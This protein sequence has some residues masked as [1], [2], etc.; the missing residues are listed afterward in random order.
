MRWL[1]LNL[2]LLE[3]RILEI[4][5][6]YANLLKSIIPTIKSK[7]N[8][9]AIDEIILFWYKNM[10]S[11]RLYLKYVFSQKDSYVFTAATFLDYD[12]KEHYPFL[13]LGEKHILDDPLCK[14]A[15]L[16][17]TFPQDSKSSLFKILNEQI[18]LTAE[19]N[20]KIIDNCQN[21]IIV[22]PLRILS[23]LDSKNKSAIIDIGEKTFLSL[24]NDID[25][26]DEY[27]EKLNT[28][29]SIKKQFIDGIEETL[30][31]SETDD[32]TKPFETRFAEAKNNSPI[33]FDKEKS[34]AYCFF[35]SFTDLYS[36]P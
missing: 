28:I 3:N 10:D 9:E 7:H 18:V 34:D 36:K 2:S 14:Y 26:I 13:L 8:V 16:S 15:E 19:D 11:V 21:Q 6:E 23:Q 4:Q 33:C 25:S 32:N 5:S 1:I 27:F 20:I 12:D 22:L 17:N 30:L 24:F 29:S 31:L 35:Q